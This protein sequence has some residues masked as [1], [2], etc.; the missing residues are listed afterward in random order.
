MRRVKKL[1]VIDLRVAS[2]AHGLTHGQ[3]GLREQRDVFQSEFE[4][5]IRDEKKPVSTPRYIASDS[6]C[7]DG[8]GFSK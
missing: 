5:M 6:A 8:L 1:D 2:G 4:S 7:F 3:T